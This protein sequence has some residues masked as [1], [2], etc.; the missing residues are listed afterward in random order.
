MIEI[1]EEELA[2]KE[3]LKCAEIIKVRA[4]VCRHCGYEHTEEELAAQQ[5]R[6]K[7][8]EG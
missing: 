6:L 2:G 7:T 3:C 4:K 5:R 1:G 8:K